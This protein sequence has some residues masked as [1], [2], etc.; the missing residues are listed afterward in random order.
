MLVFFSSCFRREQHSIA[1]NFYY[2]IRILANLLLDFNLTHF[3]FN[4]ITDKENTENSQSG[5][6]IAVTS[7]NRWKQRC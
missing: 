3:S 7:Q 2:F 6:E 4:S 1:T 5:A